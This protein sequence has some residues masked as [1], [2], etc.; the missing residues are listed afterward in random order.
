[1]KRSPY[2]MPFDRSAQQLRFAIGFPSRFARRRPVNG[3]VTLHKLQ[4]CTLS[5]PLKSDEAQ[6]IASFTHC[7]VVA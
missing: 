5:Q 6:V 3:G 1:M 4:T 7:I 2:D